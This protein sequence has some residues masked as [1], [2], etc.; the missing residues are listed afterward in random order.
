MSELKI[1]I[2]LKGTVAAVG[3]QAPECDPV[4]STVDGELPAVLERLPGL[5][6]DARARWGLNPRYPK[7]ETKLEPQPPPRTQ[8]TTPARVTRQED[9]VK[10]R[11]FEL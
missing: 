5:V 6:N 8:V 3:I 4:F 2:S 7:C 10:P 1:V 9:P 11:L